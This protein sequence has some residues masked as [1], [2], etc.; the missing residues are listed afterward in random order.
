MALV[1][2]APLTPTRPVAMPPVRPPRAIERGPLS[3]KHLQALLR[4]GLF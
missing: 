3:S 4:E 2:L 1:R